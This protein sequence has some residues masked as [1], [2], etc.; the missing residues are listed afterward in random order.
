[1]RRTDTD[2]YN[3]Q[4]VCAAVLFERE[5]YY[6]ALYGPYGAY[7]ME[8]PTTHEAVWQPF[9]ATTAGREALQQR[10]QP[11]ADSVS[12][13]P[14]DL[15]GV[16]AEVLE[17]L[18]HTLRPHRSHLL[19]TLL[20]AAFAA[21][22][23]QHAAALALAERALEASPLHRGA[24]AFT[25]TAMTR[26]ATA[27][28]KVRARARA[29]EKRVRATF[30]DSWMNGVTRAQENHALEVRRLA[31]RVRAD[32]EG[33]R[34]TRFLK[35]E[36]QFCEGARR[37]AMASFDADHVPEELRDL[38]PLARRYGVG[39]DPCRAHFVRR[40]PA[41]ERAAALRLT[42]PRLDAIQTWVSRFRPE[43]LPPEA[44]A[45]FWLL[46]ALEEMRVR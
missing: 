1:M 45:F 31:W 17:G 13:L 11:S 4:L 20:A 22:L 46:E 10:R 28:A 43:L 26:L 34:F 16:K 37:E 32:T 27:N 5:T 14:L 3:A 23:E 33:E 19:G 41:R 25:F 30:G 38:I 21:D 35:T 12:E 40:T 39:D 24:L 6:T 9:P 44:A 7:G 2:N 8:P 18:E 29:M 15:F 42:A 36:G